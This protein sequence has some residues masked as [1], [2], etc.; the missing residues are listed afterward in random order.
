LSS[1][2]RSLSNMTGYVSPIERGG[3]K[4]SHP[5]IC[6]GNCL[7]ECIQILINEKIG[8]NFA[9]YFFIGTIRSD[10][11][12]PSRHINTINIGESHRRCSR[13]KVNVMCASLL[14]H[15]YDF[16][17]GRTAHDRIIDQQNI[18]AAKFDFNCI[19]FLPYRY[20]AMLMT[21]HDKGSARITILDDPLPETESEAVGKLLSAWTACFWNRYYH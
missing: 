5:R 10:Q 14:G 9:E 6:T 13:G 17:A 16:P 12:P 1:A 8:T 11:L 3:L 15:L 19:Q 4:I 21:R 7:P 2:K 18:F 20:P